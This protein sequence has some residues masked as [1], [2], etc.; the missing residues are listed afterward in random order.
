M[1][2][3]YLKKFGQI[4]HS[5]VMTLS[6][7]FR[8]EIQIV[9]ILKN[10]YKYFK[11]L[12][13]TNSTI[14]LKEFKRFKKFRN[15]EEDSKKIDKNVNN[16]NEESESKKIDKN[17]NSENEE[18]E[19]KKIDKNVNNENEESDSKKID[20]NVNSENEESESKTVEKNI[21]NENLD[22]NNSKNVSEKLEKDLKETVVESSEEDDGL[23]YDYEETDRTKITYTA[24]EILSP[25]SLSDW[26]ITIFSVSVTAYLYYY[27]FIKIGVF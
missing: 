17:V 4:D 14:K 3:I 15:L 13:F 10:F 11:T 23:I 21:K 8:I 24:K 18:S 22:V 9:S 2:K 27:I 16:E 20:K 7:I 12:L 25:Q 6:C 26:V 1:K 19:S 5:L